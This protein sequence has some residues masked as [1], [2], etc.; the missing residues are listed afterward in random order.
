MPQTSGTPNPGT[1]TPPGAASTARLPEWPL[2]GRD[3]EFAVAR[4]VITSHGGVVLTGGAGVGKTRLA[5]ELLGV[6]AASDGRTEWIA[7]TEAAAHVTTRRRG[8]AS[9][10]SASSTASASR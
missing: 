6:V 1:S 3:D 4:E 9:A 8:A 2:V 7:A 5:W 10:C